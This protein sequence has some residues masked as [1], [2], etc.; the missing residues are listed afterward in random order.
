M[1][2]A[3]MESTLIWTSANANHPSITILF[4]RDSKSV[5]GALIS[6]S[7][8]SIHNS[9]SSISYPIF[10]QCFAI[11]ANELAD[12]ATKEATT[13]ATNTILPVSF[14]SSIQVI[15]IMIHLHTNAS[16]KF[17]VIKRLL[18]APNKSRTE[19]MTYCLLDYDP[20]TINLSI[21]IFIDSNQFKIQFARHATLMNK[22][23]ITGFANV[24]QVTP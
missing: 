4:C 22:T 24:Q 6:N 15:N 10:T 14:S 3:A 5:C 11:P 19:K 13:N 2:A 21:V 18:E 23:S 9:I 20:V 7:R 8:I 17:T 1:E 16:H 12:K